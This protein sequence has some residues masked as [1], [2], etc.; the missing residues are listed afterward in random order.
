MKGYIQV[1][2]GDAKDQLTAALGLSLR[3]A[4]AG[5]RVFI[6]QFVKTDDQIEINAFKRFSELITFEQF[7]KNGGL[8]PNPSEEDINIAKKGLQ[9]VHDV[10][11]SG[12]HD[13]VILGEAS[14][15]VTLGLFSTENILSLIAIKPSYV[16]MIITGKG[17][18]YR[19]A[20]KADLI[21][22][23]KYMKNRISL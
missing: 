1:Y 22:E 4:G 21:T 11:I 13:V 14:C 9:K 12:N 17:V 18:D 6:A 7:W 20:E 8:N 23:M 19:I 10:L 5:L 3:A 16:E 15:A 2:T